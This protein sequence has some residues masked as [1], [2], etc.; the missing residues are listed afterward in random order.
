MQ[1]T[2]NILEGQQIVDEAEGSEEWTQG[3]T[4]SRP[5]RP[6]DLD[7]NMATNGS[8]ASETPAPQP[9]AAE[10]SHFGVPLRHATMSWRSP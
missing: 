1:D 7:P 6:A 8:L 3:P 10:R 2:W 9:S 4:H 5:P